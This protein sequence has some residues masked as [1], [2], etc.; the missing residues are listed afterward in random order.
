ASIALGTLLTRDEFS[1]EVKGSGGCPPTILLKGGA[2]I[3][4]SKGDVCNFL[5]FGFGDEVQPRLGASVQVRKGQGD[6]AYANWGRYF[7]MDQK[8]AGRSLAPNR[9]F[10]IQTIFD[11]TGG[12][13]STGPLASTTGKLIDPAIKPTYTDEIVVGYA[14]PFARGYS[15]D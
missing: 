14:T 6:K 8:S 12:V 7:N 3:Y 4:R 13:L 10:Q 5:R 1:Q 11:L 2:A 15:V 9:I